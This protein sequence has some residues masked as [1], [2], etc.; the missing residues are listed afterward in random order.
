M[1]KIDRF[2]K[3]N[4]YGL[5][6][7]SNAHLERLNGILSRANHNQQIQIQSLIKQVA[8]KDEII[9]NFS[10]PRDIQGGMGART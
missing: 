6:A 9:N 2:C 4:S 1:N 7:E 10:K 3:T 5:L 8:S